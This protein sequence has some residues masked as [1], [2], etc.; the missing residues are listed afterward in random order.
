MQ[1]NSKET[2]LIS[3]SKLNMILFKLLFESMN[4]HHHT[5]KKKTPMKEW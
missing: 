1:G 2:F 4:H 5:L 3:Q